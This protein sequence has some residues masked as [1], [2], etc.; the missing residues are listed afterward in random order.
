MKGNR[1]LFGC[2]FT[3]AV[4]AFATGQERV[5]SPLGFSMQQPTAWNGID[6]GMLDENVR[7]LDLTDEAR[8]KMVSSTNNSVVVMAFTKYD[9]TKKPGVI[10]TIQVRM[11]PNPVPDFPTFME[12]IV[13]NMSPGKVPFESYEFIEQ[14]KEISLSGFRTVNIHSRYVLHTQ[15]GQTLN[16]RTRIYAVP[17]GKQFFQITFMDDPKDEDCTM[18]FD[19]LVKTIKLVAKP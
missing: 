4:A 17:Y 6:K 1:V 18:E 9:P 12:A 2:L 11:L 5:S 19:A 16:V 3:L 7:K 8:A 10:P 13:R 14:P 15:D